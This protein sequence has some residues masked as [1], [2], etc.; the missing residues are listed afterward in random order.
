MAG[1]NKGGLE[2]DI[3]KK[4]LENQENVNKGVAELTKEIDAI[5]AQLKTVGSDATVNMEAVRKEFETARA[6]Y[7]ALVKNIRRQSAEQI[8]L[9]GAEDSR[10]SISRALV[11]IKKNDWKDAGAEKELLDQAEVKAIQV[12]DFGKRGGYFLPNLVMAEVIG[13]VYAQSVLINY[14][15]SGEGTT[16]VSVVNG[17][18]AET[19]TIRKVRG[20]VVSY[21][22]GEEDALAVSAMNVGD[23]SWKLREL[24]NLVGLTK[25][26]M[27]FGGSGF[28]SLLNNDM[29]RSL[30]AKLDLTGLYGSGTDNMPRGI[31]RLDGVTK[32]SAK[33]QAAVTASTGP[34]SPNDLGAELTF[35]G[36]DEMVGA[37]TDNNYALDSSAAFIFHPRYGR[38]LKQ[39]KVENYTGQQGQ[40]EYLLGL[41]RIPDSKLAEIIGP[42]GTSTQMPT[43][44]LPGQKAG[45]TTGSTETKFGD[46][47]FGNWSDLVLVAGPGLRVETDDGKGTGFASGVTFM[48]MHGYFDFVCR[49]AAA[50]VHCPDARMSN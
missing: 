44:L 26:M 5:K 32:F 36:L 34:G 46:V 10:F 11:A 28:D 18:P 6:G 48:K 33:T 41:P 39:I 15:G 30:V 12:G 13:A 40:K 7:T 1:E 38:R 31:T 23:V 49:Y 25:K 35:D 24:G 50:F 47:L 2:A 37:V 14:G 22:V 20:G 43:N 4:L 17:V 27:D 19:G 29:V 3:A 16:R 45:W 21:W 9:P 42:F 8:G